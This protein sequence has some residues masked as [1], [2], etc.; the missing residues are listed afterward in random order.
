MLTQ[1]VYC[2]HEDKIIFEISITTLRY[3][4]IGTMLMDIITVEYTSY[5]CPQNTSCRR[6]K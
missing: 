6:G 3:Q 4:L 5:L 1:D 2:S